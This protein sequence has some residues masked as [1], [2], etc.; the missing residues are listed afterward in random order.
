M[1]G[2]EKGVMANLPF[3]Y[4]GIYSSQ[5][6]QGKFLYVARSFAS[7]CG[8]SV[9]CLRNHLPISPKPYSSEKSSSTWGKWKQL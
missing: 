1:T 6:M 7:F 3:Y 9:L 8:I 5:L 4:L 2:R